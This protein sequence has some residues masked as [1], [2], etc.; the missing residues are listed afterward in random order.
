MEH[1]FGIPHTFR[2]VDRNP[3]PIAQARDQN[4]K[5]QFFAGE[6]IRFSP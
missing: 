4:H 6:G 1:G 3:A 5:A 2:V